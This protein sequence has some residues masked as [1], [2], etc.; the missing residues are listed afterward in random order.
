MAKRINPNNP[1]HKVPAPGAT[2][3]SN[4][5][6]IVLML[7]LINAASNGSLQILDT[8]YPVKLELFS[9]CVWMSLVTRGFLGYS[10]QNYQRLLVRLLGESVR[11]RKL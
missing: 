3:F 9:G 7:P 1:T 8:F 6:L 5:S 11:S 2:S 4:L 10:P